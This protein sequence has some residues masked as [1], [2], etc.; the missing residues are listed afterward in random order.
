MINEIAE[1]DILEE[2]KVTMI[3]WDEKHS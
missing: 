3:H 2:K 1:M